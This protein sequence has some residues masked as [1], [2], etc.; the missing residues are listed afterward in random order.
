[1]HRVSHG[2]ARPRTGCA[3]RYTLVPRRRACA[4]LGRIRHQERRP[5]KLYSYFRSSA[6]Y[7]VRIALNLKRLPYDYVPVHMLRDGGQQLKDEY[8]ALNPDALVPTLVDGD[9]TLQQ[10]LAIIEYLDETH[11]EPALLP[12]A[13]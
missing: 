7:R 11:P 9:A 2:R 1:M 6:S 8:R 10:S 5:M 4:C 12:K 13:P 3:R